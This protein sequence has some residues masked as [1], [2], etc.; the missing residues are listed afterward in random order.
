MDRSPIDDAHAARFLPLTGL[1]NA[2]D[3]GGLPLAGGGLTRHGRLLRSDAPLALGPEDRA[4]L[5]LFGL[6]TVVDLR[7]SH[8]LA[9]EPNGLAGHDGIAIEHVEVWSLINATGIEPA[10]PWDITAFYL[11]ALDHAGPAFA[12]AARL[13]ADAE[14][15]AMFHCTVGKDRTGLLALLILET[16]GVTRDAVI[17]DFAL[18]E[19][20]IGPIRERLLLDAEE[21]GIARRDFVRLLGA[22]PDLIEPA[23]EHLDRRHGGAEAYLLRHGAGATTVARLRSKLRG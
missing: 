10:D 5:T 2:R 19:P 3:L 22:T 14:G 23:L 11:A 20:R 9:R 17:E 12:T 21:R 16:V 6:T 1:L 8:E 18:T 13:L 4:H 7:E 15:A